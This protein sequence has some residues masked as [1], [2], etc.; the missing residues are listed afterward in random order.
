MIHALPLPP[1]LFHWRVWTL[2]VASGGEEGW[3]PAADTSAVFLP[4]A[5]ENL[6]ETCV[7]ED[8]THYTGGGGR[9]YG[10]ES[11]LILSVLSGV[12]RW[13]CP[14]LNLLVWE[15]PGTLETNIRDVR[16][17]VSDGSAS[18]ER[19]SPPRAVFLSWCRAFG[20]L[21]GCIKFNK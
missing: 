17:G 8:Q 7:A 12:S 21:G 13:S 20:D 19:S 18:L 9:W 6:I 5:L 1:M 15:Q 3:R 14:L 11:R 4:L 16:D 2:P 10:A